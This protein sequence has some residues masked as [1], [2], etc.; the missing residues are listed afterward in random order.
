L[1]S[2]VPISK[3][4]I[5]MKATERGNS[6]KRVFLLR[7]KASW[8][9]LSAVAIGAMLLLLSA[10]SWVES[11]PAK[12][13]TVKPQP[14]PALAQSAATQQPPVAKA[15]SMPASRGLNT[16][17]NVHGHWVIDVKNPDGTLARHVE[18]ENS[19]DPGFTILGQNLP[20]GAAFLSALMTGQAVAPV[21][22]WM[23]LLGGPAGLANVATD[24]GGPCSLVIESLGNPFGGCVLGGP[25]SFFCTQ[26]SGVSGAAAIVSCNLTAIPV[27]RGFQ[28]SGSIAASN[29]GQIFTV[30]TLA[31]EACGPTSSPVANCALSASAGMDSFTSSS[32]F[33]GAPISVTTGQGIAVTVTIT[34]ASGS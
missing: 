20:G 16:T 5:V 4:R 22:S 17:V 7:D 31:G 10:A 27:T 6:F 1:L 28:L 30:A 29:T 21:G 9:T 14:A 26:L 11:A 23:I 12:K 24:P 13:Q 2:N 18:F 34:F 15:P 32:N 8:R 25:N 19:L 3:R 33:P